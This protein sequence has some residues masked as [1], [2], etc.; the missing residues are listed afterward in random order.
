ML[1]DDG[2]SPPWHSKEAAIP[3][4]SGTAIVPDAGNDCVAA[5]QVDTV[6]QAGKQLGKLASWHDLGWSSSSWYEAPDSWA[7][8]WAAQTQDGGAVEQREQTEPPTPI[9]NRL[10][11]KT[12]PDDL[13]SPSGSKAAQTD[14][15]SNSKEDSTADHNKT[16]RKD[17]PP[18]TKRRKKGDIDSTKPPKPPNV[19]IE[20]AS[21]PEDLEMEQINEA[22]KNVVKQAQDKCSGGLELANELQSFFNPSPFLTS[23]AKN[24]KLELFSAVALV[25]P[26]ITTA[27]NLAA[28]NKM[29]LGDKKNVFERCGS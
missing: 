17:T 25:E 1:D 19:P 11:K 22:L 14:E 16:E 7:G 24:T 28:T 26:L 8:S 10:L 4:Q 5:T 6:K 21:N 13:S 3:E 27:R 23:Q 20:V 9:T 18:P 15:G 29:K 2:S 12:H